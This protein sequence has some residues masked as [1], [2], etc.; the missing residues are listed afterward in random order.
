MSIATLTLVHVII[1][2]VAIASGLAVT[3]DLLRGKRSSA[4]N[5]LFLTTT[6]ATSVTGFFFGSKFGPPHVLGVISLALLA[7]ATYGLVGRLRITYIVTALASL[8]LNVF[9]GVVQAFQKVPFL[10]ALAA[11]Q[12]EPPFAAA[13]GIVLLAFVVVG[14]LAIK[15][16]RDL[17][18]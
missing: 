18:R 4:W 12:S 16:S 5:G 13:Q 7:A 17:P 11:T 1:S 2:L 14:W 10:H 15:R 8:Y 9:V 3:W 6:V